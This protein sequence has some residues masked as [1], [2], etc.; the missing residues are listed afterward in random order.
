MD[1]G[2]KMPLKIVSKVGAHQV[3]SSFISYSFGADASS[4]ICCNSSFWYNNVWMI[5]AD[6]CHSLVSSCQLK[7]SRLLG[8]V[9]SYNSHGSVGR[10]LADS[11]V[12][13][14]LC[15]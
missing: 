13:M 14:A 4:H 12:N 3:Y 5:F 1:Q 8:R 11:F 6:L 2:K 15:T 10:S 9:S 7:A